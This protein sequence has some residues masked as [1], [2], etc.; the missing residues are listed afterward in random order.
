MHMNRLILV[1][2]LSLVACHTKQKKSWN[3]AEQDLFRESCVVNSKEGLGE[4]RSRKYCD[5]ML[6]K[7][8]SK[9]PDANE[10]GKLSLTETR[11]MAK[12]CLD[13]IPAVPDSTSN[14]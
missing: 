3:K 13:E 4:Q 2:V 6:K 14:Q 8:E 9:Y 5:C 7:V 10:A 1:L 11:E 12:G